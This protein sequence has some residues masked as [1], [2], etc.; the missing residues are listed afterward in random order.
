MA[1]KK[2][3]EEPASLNKIKIL[4]VEDDL[5]MQET[6]NDILSAEG[7]EIT[8]VKYFLCQDQS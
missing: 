4:I 7:Y 1:E 6:L 2:D 3:L 8:K 5:R